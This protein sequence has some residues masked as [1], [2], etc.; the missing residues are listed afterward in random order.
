MGNTTS[1]SRKEK[2]GGKRG[3]KK[4]GKKG[5]DQDKSGGDHAHR[6]GSSEDS[7]EGGNGRDYDNERDYETKPGN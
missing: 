2:K 4:G 6:G 1:S 5:K 3:G 7:T